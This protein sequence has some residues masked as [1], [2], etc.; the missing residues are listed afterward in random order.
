MGVVGAPH[1]NRNHCVNAE[2]HGRATGFE[3]SLTV[4]SDLESIRPTF[5]PWTRALSWLTM[6]V[7]RLLATAQVAQVKRCRDL[8]K[9]GAAAEKVFEV[10][11]VLE[12]SS[13]RARSERQR[14]RCSTGAA[15]ADR[16]G[17][18]ACAGRQCAAG[19]R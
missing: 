7:Q 14:V 19:H 18:G 8:L 16:R 13:R 1:E 6:I 10:G 17:H 3:V 11:Q 15:G 9:Q 2:K 12:T 5:V 4:P